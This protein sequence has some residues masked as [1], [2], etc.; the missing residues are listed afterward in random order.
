MED[1]AIPQYDTAEPITLSPLQEENFRQN[2]DDVLRK[3][4]AE[5]TTYED[6]ERRKIDDLENRK[7]LYLNHAQEMGRKDKGNQ[8]Y[9][10]REF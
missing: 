3:L 6:K 4:D 2:L 7:S 1:E 5:T 8:S 10:E 9:H